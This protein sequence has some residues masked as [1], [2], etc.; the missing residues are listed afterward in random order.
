MLQR[1]ATMWWLRWM[2]SGQI[3]RLAVWVMP[4]SQHRDTIVEALNS[5]RVGTPARQEPA[6]Q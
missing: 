2:L 3:M 5:V 1:I 6:S 4:R